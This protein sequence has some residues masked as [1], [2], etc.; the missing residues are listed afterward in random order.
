LKYFVE[1]LYAPEYEP[2]TV[3]FYQ[4]DQPDAEPYYIDDD[5]RDDLPP[6][7][8]FLINEI[9]EAFNH[10]AQILHRMMRGYLKRLYERENEVTS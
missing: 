3:R 2:A 6:Y 1:I 9:V 7:E 8:A 10:P 4:L 5:K